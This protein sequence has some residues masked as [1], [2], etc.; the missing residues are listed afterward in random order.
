MDPVSSNLLVRTSSACPD[1]SVKPHCATRFL[2]HRD[3]EM[4][5]DIFFDRRTVKDHFRGVRR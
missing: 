3:R 1:A 4:P 2:L 5:N